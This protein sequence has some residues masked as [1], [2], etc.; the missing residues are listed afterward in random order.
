VLDVE[1]LAAVERA[2]GRVLR[3]EERVVRAIGTDE[4]LAALQAVP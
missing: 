4:D 3:M 2:R 1:D